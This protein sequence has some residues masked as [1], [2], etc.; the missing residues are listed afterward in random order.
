M[1][2]LVFMLTCFLFFAG[3]VFALG[4]NEAEVVESDG[5]PVLV[6]T[7]GDDASESIYLNDEGDL[8]V[9]FGNESSFRITWTGVDCIG[10]GSEY[11]PKGTVILPLKCDRFTITVP[12]ESTSNPDMYCFRIDR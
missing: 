1:K 9:L 6:Q 4:E 5:N 8:V 10:A 12:G 11:C 7:C 2:K 3:S